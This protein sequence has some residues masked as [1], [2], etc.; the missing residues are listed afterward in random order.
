MKQQTFQDEGQT[1]KCVLRPM[2]TVKALMS[3]PHKDISTPGFHIRQIRDLL[4]G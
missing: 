3:L 4:I 1:R 2:L